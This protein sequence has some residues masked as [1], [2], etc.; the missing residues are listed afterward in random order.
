[1]RQIYMQTEEKETINS[2]TEM[3]S[4]YFERQIK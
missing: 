4:L 1:M 2:L 3:L